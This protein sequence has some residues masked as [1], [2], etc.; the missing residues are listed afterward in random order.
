MTKRFS[1]SPHPPAIGVVRPLAVHDA[2]IHRCAALNHRGCTSFSR[3]IREI[4]IGQG[5]NGDCSIRCRS[6]TSRNGVGD[7]VHPRTRSGGENCPA[8][9]MQLTHDADQS[10]P[11]SSATAVAGSWSKQYSGIKENALLVFGVTVNVAVPVA[12]HVPSMV[13]VRSHAGPGDLRVKYAIRSA[14][15]GASAVQLPPLVTGTITTSPVPSQNSGHRF[16]RLG[17]FQF[18]PLPW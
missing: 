18:P 13:Y 17:R 9:E 16:R 11:A 6:A 15:V 8:V 7:G 1:S 14:A 10:P 2:R 4:S 12:G 5:V 3:C